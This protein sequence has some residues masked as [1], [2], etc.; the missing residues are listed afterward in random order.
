MMRLAVIIPC[1]NEEKSIGRV[2]EDFRRYL[3]EA[4][5]YVYDNNSQDRTVDIAQAHGA[6]VRSER[7]QGKGHVIR[8]MFRDVEA[9][10]YV[11]VDGDATYQVS[12]APDMVKSL[13]EEQLDMVIGRRIAVQENAA[14]RKGHVLGNRLFTKAVTLL[15]GRSFEDIFSGYR[16]FSRRFVK[17]FPVSSTGFEIETELAV[18]SL[19]QGMAVA[20]IDTEYYARPEGSH[21]KL[22]T[23]RDGFRILRT[24][25][26]FLRLYRPLAFYGSISLVLAALA[27]A[28]GVPVIIHYMETGLV[29]RLPTAVL[30]TGLFVLSAIALTCGL[31][32]DAVSR[33]NKAIKQLHYLSQ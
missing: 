4:T 10:V 8:R 29:E 21:S 31:I 13:V 22:N 2:L 25:V 18:H 9:D 23:Y 20:E 3:P 33:M 1:Y 30:C 11:M 19:D 14:Y 5:L 28:L 15:F 12:K 26:N 17:S 27:L 7:R 32:L 24:V 16:V 6:V